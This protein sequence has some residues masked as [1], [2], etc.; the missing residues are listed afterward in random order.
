MNIL[1]HTDIVSISNALQGSLIDS[2]TYD[3]LQQELKYLLDR[4]PLKLIDLLSHRIDQMHQAV[5]LNN[6]LSAFTPEEYSL[7]CQH[8]LLF[9]IL[10]LMETGFQNSKTRHMVKI[11][12]SCS[13]RS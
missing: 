8:S 2:T 7:N 9:S 12:S 6:E 1:S 13:T 11:E 4:I 5:S 3:D 10:L